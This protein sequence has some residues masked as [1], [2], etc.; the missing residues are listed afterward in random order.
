M[1]I[2]RN[3]NQNEYQQTT[4]YACN[5]HCGNITFLQGV[6]FF[7]VIFVVFW[8]FWIFLNIGYAVHVLCRMTAHTLVSHCWAR[9]WTSIRYNQIRAHSHAWM[10]D[11]VNNLNSVCFTKMYTYLQGNKLRKWFLFKSSILSYGYLYML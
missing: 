2:K 6:I 5:I 11:G 9:H 7:S 8:C 10:S 4:T 3:L 1:K